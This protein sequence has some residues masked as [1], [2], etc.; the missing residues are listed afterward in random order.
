MKP[1]SVVLKELGID[2][3]DKLLENSKKRRAAF[4][5]RKEMQENEKMFENDVNVA[6]QVEKRIAS[7]GESYTKDEYLAHYPT[8]REATNK[9]FHSASEKRLDQDDLLY[10]KQE[11]L[12]FYGGYDE[13]DRSLKE[14]EVDWKW[15]EHRLDQND[16]SVLPKQAF[17][18][19]YGYTTGSDEWYAGLDYELP[20]DFLDDRYDPMDIDDDYHYDPMDVDEENQYLDY[21]ET[22]DYEV[23]VAPEFDIEMG[24]PRTRGPHPYGSTDHGAGDAPN[25]AF[26]GAGSTW[27]NEFPLLGDD[28]DGAIYNQFAWNDELPSPQNDEE[29]L[30]TLSELTNIF[31]PFAAEKTSNNPWKRF[32]EEDL[33][34]AEED[35]TMSAAQIQSEV[36]QRHKKAKE[37]LKKLNEKLQ[38]AQSEKSTKNWNK[39]AKKAGKMNDQA[40]LWQ[41]FFDGI[42]SLDTSERWYNLAQASEALTQVKSEDSWKRIGDLLLKKENGDEQKAIENWHTLYNAA[43]TDYESKTTFPSDAKFDQ[44]LQE[45]IAEE[46][47]EYNQ[48]HA[49]R[50]LVENAVSL[51][52]EI[53]REHQKLISQTKNFRAAM[54]VPKW[55][56]LAEGVVSRD[57]AV[58]RWKSVSETAQEYLPSI[59]A[60]RRWKSMTTSV[61]ADANFK[62]LAERAVAMQKN[63]KKWRGLAGGLIATDKLQK[64][65]VDKLL[66]ACNNRKW[67]ILGKSVVAQEKLR[68]LADAALADAYNSEKFQTLAKGLKANDQ[69]KN[70]AVKLSEKRASEQVDQKTINKAEALVIAAQ[71]AANEIENEHGS[72]ASNRLRAL[73]DAAVAD[74]QNMK[75]WEAFSQGLLNKPSLDK[76]GEQLQQQREAF[77][78]WKENADG[79]DWT[80]YYTAP[81]AQQVQGPVTNSKWR[82][83]AEEEIELAFKKRPILQNAWRKWT[84]E[85]MKE[86]K[87][88]DKTLKLWHDLAKQAAKT[89]KTSDMWQ[90]LSALAK[91]NDDIAK[92]WSNLSSGA[93][94][95]NQLEKN[96]E[97]LANGLSERE[98]MKKQPVIENA[99]WRQWTKDD[100]TDINKER[101]AARNLQNLAKKLKIKS[102]DDANRW[103]LPASHRSWAFSDISDELAEVN[104]NQNW[105]K[106]AQGAVRKNN[107]NVKNWQK[108][109]EKTSQK[110]T[111]PSSKSK[112]HPINQWAQEDLKE[113]LETP[114]QKQ[115]NTKKTFEKL[116]SNLLKR[117]ADKD[118][119]K[120]LAQEA[121]KE[122]RLFAAKKQQAAG[123]KD[124]AAAAAVEAKRRQDEDFVMLDEDVPD[125]DAVGS[126]AKP[127][128]QGEG[129]VVM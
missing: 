99:A 21:P 56:K 107:K 41:K 3:F 18:E 9:W 118:A 119:Y 97:K 104:A 34:E 78:V 65:A 61:V 72:L 121:A 112:S 80:D 79:L 120:N 111:S 42:E 64:L 20:Q 49:S 106:L 129:C 92:M 85:D 2:N 52:A 115:R 116:A 90:S 23:P 67:Q 39:L 62:N 76:S 68:N 51:S 77:D 63:D 30:A 48:L 57:N 88:D 60:N 94:S 47:E 98:T 46:L 82:Q 81:S 66:D 5:K 87:K 32:Y 1:R 8:K 86:T 71:K 91:K 38:K 44:W 28:P 73:A 69:L 117:D 33:A 122:G 24:L 53:E 55:Q 43:K 13:W 40:E 113:A 96:W 70:L 59:K 114:G 100:V 12:E 105:E 7:D 6:V 95:Q 14:S 108:L 27:N 110:T 50:S 127:E 124:V 75:L 58:K 22:P 123:W 4:E 128:E 103:N 83:W 10:T 89:E 11:F 84:E 93:V 101:K 36:K 45:D 31:K 109:A 15:M 17:I 26:L 16:G 125:D 37:N 102:E 54:N 29:E 74:A 126:P 35:M 25:L 19:K